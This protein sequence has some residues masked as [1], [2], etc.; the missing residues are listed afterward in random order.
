MSTPVIMS[1]F[2]SPSRGKSGDSVSCLRFWC[3][4][5]YFLRAVAALFD[6]WL[7]DLVFVCMLL[8]L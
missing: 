1:A 5:L 7:L 2:L 4:N 8:R 3:K 6:L